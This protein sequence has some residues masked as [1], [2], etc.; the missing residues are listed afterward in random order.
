MTFQKD[1]FRLVPIAI[2]L[3]TL[4]VGAMMAVK[5]LKYSILILQ[6]T[7]LPLWS[8]CLDGGERTPLR[9]RR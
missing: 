1:F 7:I 5:V 2:L 8:A 9:P 6:T 3:S 4:Q